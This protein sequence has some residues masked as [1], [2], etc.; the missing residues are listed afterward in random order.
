[1]FV[2]PVSPCQEA[3]RTIFSDI[4]EPSYN[5]TSLSIQRAFAQGF[6]KMTKTALYRQIAESIRQE[7]LHQTLRPGDRLPS[8]R[9]MATKWTCT[10]GT[11]QRAYDTLAQQNLVVSR[12]G[13]GT[14]VAVSVL[15]EQ[16]EP[17]RRAA[18]VHRAESFLLEV[19]TAGYSTVEI[20][21]AIRL[22]LDRWRTFRTEATTWPEQSVRF[23]GSHDLA[24]TAIAAHF[25]EF[26]PGY[27]PQ[28]TFSGSLGGLIALAEGQADLAGLHLWDEESDSYN[29]P[30]IRRLLPGRRVAVLTLAHRNL[31]LMVLPA[32]P[33]QITGLADLARPAIHFI[34]RQ[35]GAGTRV[36]FDVQVRRLGLTPAQIS[37]YNEEVETHSAVARAI[38]EERAQVGLGL[39]AAALA[40]GLGFIPLKKERYDLVIPAEVWPK[41]PIQALARWLVTD[42]AKQEIRQLGGYDVTDTGN[43]EWVIA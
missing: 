9:E 32:N 22:A 14:H 26:A 31:G 13:Q 39:E 28:L 20:E 25:D 19:L 18:L 29:L 2:Q 43:L 12:P 7:I 6:E 17:L 34:N 10:I 33:L 38:A 4:C 1:M 15:L 3:Y 8:V 41:G 36:W 37:G 27:E 16:A 30:F 21:Q 11:I 24:L 40:Y 23:A 35:A 42:S 5:S